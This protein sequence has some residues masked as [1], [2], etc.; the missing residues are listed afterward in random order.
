MN[1]VTSDAFGG[2]WLDCVRE[3][4]IAHPYKKTDEGK[5][6]E[7][8]ANGTGIT[9][10]VVADLRTGTV[11]FVVDQFLLKGMIEEFTCTEQQTEKSKRPYSF[12]REG[13]KSG[14]YKT[15]Q[16]ENNT[17]NCHEHKDDQ[18]YGPDILLHM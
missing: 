18:R 10:A 4:E 7:A 12:C 5:N 14:L 2:F 13:L 3:E 6:I 15:E 9:S 16:D 8:I 11:L 1:Y 17:D